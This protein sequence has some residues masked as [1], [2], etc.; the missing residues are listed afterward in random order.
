MPWFIFYLICIGLFI[1]YK[2]HQ[3]KK[4]EAY[5][6]EWGYFD[7]RFYMH[8]MDNYKDKCRNSEPVDLYEAILLA[9]ITSDKESRKTAID[10]LAEML[11]PEDEYIKHFRKEHMRLD[12]LFEALQKQI[13][14]R[15]D[16]DTISY[17]KYVAAKPNCQFNKENIRRFSLAIDIF[18]Q[19]AVS[20]YSYPSTKHIERFLDLILNK[21]FANERDILAARVKLFLITTD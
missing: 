11:S 9:I 2:V 8:F 10:R 4:R 12:F 6:K 3:W 15:L 5:C 13:H 20:P 14:S 18:F 17:L 16:D 1:I 21:E 19:W 7:E